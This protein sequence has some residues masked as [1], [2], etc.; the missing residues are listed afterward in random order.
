MNSKGSLLAIIIII[1]IL[2][3]T[4]TK[5]TSREA[6][7]TAEEFYFGVSF[8]GQ[9]AQQAKALIDKIMNYTNLFIINSYDLSTNET[10]LNE[11][12]DYTAQAGLNFIVYFDFISRIAYPWHQTW[13]DAAKDRWGNSFL[14]IYLRDELGGKQ[15]DLQETVKNA[16][17]YSDAANRFVDN[18]TFSNSMIDAKNKNIKTFTADY[19]LYW[20]IYRS[21]YDTVFA[22]LGWGLDSVQQV[23]LC[24]GAAS[25]QGKDWGAIIV[26]EDYE[27]PYLGSARE[28]YND[29]MLAYS[30]GAKYVVVFNYPTYPE[31]NPYGIL[32]DE[33][34]EVLEQFWNYV[35]ANPRGDSGGAEA[36]LV[37]PEDYGWGMR[38]NK[39]IGVDNIWGLWPEDEKSPVILENID[40]LLGEYG[41]GLDIIYGD[42]VLDF[43]GK[44]DKVFFWNSTLNSVAN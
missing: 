34:F 23:A 37:L 29:M 35:N 24:R 13:L 38:R 11:V 43:A 1:S 3:C 4:Y 22:E 15:I 42:D 40:Q 25:M 31:S 18:I 44:Y 9:T 7:V 28:I 30:G 14:G 33:H 39:Y 12:C 21:G 19:A 5:E 27:P 17:D 10:A 16:A 8:G 32:S 36:A 6:A 20:W 41:L 26:W 2:T